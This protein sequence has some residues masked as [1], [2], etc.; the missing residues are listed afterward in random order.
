MQ[1]KGAAINDDAGLEREADAM[2]ARALAPAVQ[3]SGGPEEA[4]LVESRFA[5]PERMARSS[6]AI[7]SRKRSASPIARG[8]PAASRPVVQRNEKSKELLKGLAAPKTFSLVGP[9]LDAHKAIVEKLENEFA[10]IK[11]EELPLYNPSCLGGIVLN[12]ANGVD[13]GDLIKSAQLIDLPPQEAKDPRSRAVGKSSFDLAKEAGVQ[14]EIVSNTLTTMENAGQLAYLRESGLLAD[15][16]WE[17]VVEIHYYR[18]RLASQTKLHKDTLGQTLFVNL[19]YVNAEP[20]QGPEFIINPELGG[21]TLEKTYLQYMADKLP[22]EFIDDVQAVKTYSGDPTEIGMSE[23]PAYGVVSFVD[24]LI[25]HKTP[26]MGHRKANSGYISR[27]LEKKY[28]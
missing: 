10:K 2:G 20:I 13:L 27:A 23:I 17:I 28:P 18:D 16:S 7:Q 15:K 12:P 6:T 3:L 9:E 26:T 22:K 1:M 4:A 11:K 14:K 5:S 25:H 21:K 19:N 8:G 24:E